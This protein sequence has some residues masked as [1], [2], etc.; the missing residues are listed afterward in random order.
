MGLIPGCVVLLGSGLRSGSLGLDPSSGFCAGSGTMFGLGATLG[1]GLGLGDGFG[2]GAGVGLV[3]G[4]GAVVGRG[5]EGCIGLVFGGVD[6]P[7]PVGPVGPP[8]RVEGLVRGVVVGFVIVGEGLGVV[9]ALAPDGVPSCAPV[10]GT[11]IAAGA[12]LAV[13]ATST[14]LL[15]NRLPPFNPALTPRV[16][17]TT[18]RAA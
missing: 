12:P 8:G 5:L 11:R 2:V 16:P 1:L 10:P 7:G 18:A 6:F 15:T 9:E 14:A 4:L 17:G 13:V 3:S